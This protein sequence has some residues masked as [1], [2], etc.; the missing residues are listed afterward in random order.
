MNAACHDLTS[1]TMYFWSRQ[2]SR[3]SGTATCCYA[4]NDQRNRSNKW[5]TASSFPSGLSEKSAFIFAV[6]DST[7]RLLAKHSLSLA[8]FSSLLTE[9]LRSA[10]FCLQTAIC[11]LPLRDQGPTKPEPSAEEQGNLYICYK[12]AETMHPIIPLILLLLLLGVLAVIGFVVCGI[13]SEIAAKTSEKMSENNVQLGP[14][15]I[16]I[17]VKQVKDEDY[18]GRTQDMLVKAWNLSSWP[19]Y[20][21]RIWNKDADINSKKSKAASSRRSKASGSG[22]ASADAGAQRPVYVQALMPP[23][24]KGGRNDEVT[25][26]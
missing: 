11:I 19:A 17:G 21:S 6:I 14:E 10:F 7:L 13:M 1:W 16:R 2:C 18:V 12:P 8:K 9:W 4:S 3:F 22:S 24:R 25:I 26:Q 20:R 23:P 15:G 5:R